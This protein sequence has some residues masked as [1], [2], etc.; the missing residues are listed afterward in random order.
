MFSEGFVAN[1]FGIA[2]H[3]EQALRERDKTCVYCHK[4]MKTFHFV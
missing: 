3:D 2:L 1:R 4:A